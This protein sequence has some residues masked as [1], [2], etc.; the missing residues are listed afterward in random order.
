ML[1]A[2]V[3][4]PAAAFAQPVG[5][6]YVLSLEN[7]SLAELMAVPAAWDIVLKHLPGLKLM[8]GTP[9]MKPHLHNFTVPSLGVFMPNANPEVY[10]TVDRELAQLPPVQDSDR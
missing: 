6:P 10:A 1:I 3:Y 5:T 9:M 4:P 2:P 7:A 8:T